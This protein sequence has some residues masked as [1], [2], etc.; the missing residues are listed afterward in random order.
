MTKATAGSPISTR[1]VTECRR[2]AERSRPT[3]PA[4]ASASPSSVDDC[5][6]VRISSSTARSTSST[7][8][9]IIAEPGRAAVNNRPATNTTTGAAASPTTTRVRRTSTPV[10]TPAAKVSSVGVASRSPLGSAGSATVSIRAQPDSNPSP[11]A[12]TASSVGSPEFVASK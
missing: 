7:P 5:R 10:T 3:A 9:S 12:V 11:T 6:L 2:W 1:P 4:D 8:V